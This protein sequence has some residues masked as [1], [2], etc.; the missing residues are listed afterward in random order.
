MR[1]V[2][3]DLGDEGVVFEA[4]FKQTRAECWLMGDNRA[5]EVDDGCH[6]ELVN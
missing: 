2:L 3:I 5:D 4:E 1:S 6:N